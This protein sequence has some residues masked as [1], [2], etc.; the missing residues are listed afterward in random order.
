MLHVGEG[1]EQLE[2]LYIASGSVNCLQPSWKNI[3]QYLLKLNIRIPH[4]KQLLF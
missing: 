1:M 3:W 4:D 2:L